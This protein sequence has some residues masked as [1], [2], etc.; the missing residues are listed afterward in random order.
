MVRCV[1]AMDFWCWLWGV[2][3]RGS[4]ACMEGGWAA[5]K[6][7]P[8]PGLA[9]VAVEGG[10]FIPGRISC[11]EEH[12]RMRVGCLKKLGKFRGENGLWKV[13]I[14]EEEEISHE[15]ESGRRGRGSG[16]RY[17]VNVSPRPAH[18]GQGFVFPVQVA[19]LSN[20]LKE[21]KQ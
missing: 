5:G 3:A 15:G 17:V 8:I 11:P 1:G 9:G 4:V 13:K 7:F 18:G 2:E 6:G 16:M 14:R 21:E 20:F 19:T 10:H 12:K